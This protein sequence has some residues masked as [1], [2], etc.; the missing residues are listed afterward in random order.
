MKKLLSFLL[1]LA[2]MATMLASCGG[3]DESSSDNS[4]VEETTDIELAKEYLRGMYKD[5]STSTS[6]DFTRVNTLMV[7]STSYT[8]EWTVEVENNAVSVEKGDKE[9]T[10]KI[11]VV[12]PETAIEYILK[13]TIKDGDGNTTET[14]FKYTIPAYE[15]MGFEAYYSAAA[16]DSVIVKGVVSAIIATSKGNSNNSLY[17]QDTDGGYYIYGLSSDPV[18]DLNLEVGMTVMVSGVKDIYNGTHEVKDATV[19]IV[20]SNKTEVI[21]LDYTDLFKNA[22]SLKDEAL[23]KKQGALVTIKGVEITGIS[24]SNNTY[25]M[26]KLGD[27]ETYVR[28][29]SSSCPLTTDEQTTFVATYNENISNSATV[30]GIISVYDS[31]FYLTPAT[32]DAFSEFAAIERTDAEKIAA[33]KENISIPESFAV[34]KEVE[35]LTK[36][37]TFTDVKISYASDNSSVVVKNGKLIVTLSDKEQTAKVTATITCGEASDTVEFTLTLGAKGKEEKPEGT[38]YM[39]ALAQAQIGKNLYFT[40]EMDGNFLATSEKASDA[41]KVYIETVS[42]GYRFYFMNDGKRTYIDI[43]EYT[44]GK[45]GVQIT[46]EPTCVFTKH[47]SGVYVA[48]VAGAD[49]YLGTYNTFTTFSASKISYITGDNAANIGVSQFIA[50][51]YTSELPKIDV[52]VVDDPPVVDNPSE[53]NVV[54]SPK[55]NTAYKFAL[56]QASLGQNLYLTGEMSSYYLATTED[57]SAGVDV[58]LESAT[59]GYYLYFKNGSTKTYINIVERTDAA[60]KVTI[61][62]SEAPSNVY[63]WDETMGIL[64]TNVAGSDWYLG[65]YSTYTTMSPSNTS[66]ITGDNA[67]KVGVSQFPAYLVTK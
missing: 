52:P 11:N 57:A 17:V 8:V 44:A 60:G 55:A 64:I 9:D 45:A 58:Y 59:G 7:G 2:M 24:T 18:T 65:T 39:F 23:V 25:Y 5:N 3:D 48:N 1:V 67:S 46:T 31:K 50:G 4:T 49:Y 43:H 20:D 27:K 66:Y 13:A 32:V 53:L 16:G 51:F 34:N 41:V 14:S 6:S 61:N 10:I 36:G 62:L 28:I 15:E 54:T 29:S 30:T 40:G 42:G 63:T 19:E 56:S 22:T 21:A 35:L 33:E 37:K 12:K 26:F 47:E 38:A